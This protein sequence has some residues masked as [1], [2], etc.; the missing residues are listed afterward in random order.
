M[1]VLCGEVAGLD[2]GEA[3]EDLADEEA[4]GKDYVGAYV[5]GLAPCWFGISQGSKMW[6]E[7][8]IH[9]KRRSIEI[10]DDWQLNMLLWRKGWIR[11]TIVVP[12]PVSC[13]ED[14]VGLRHAD[15]VGCVVEVARQLV[16]V[17]ETAL[18]VIRQMIKRCG[19]SGGSVK[20]E[21]RV[22]GCK[23]RSCNVQVLQPLGCCYE[24]CKGS[25][26][27]CTRVARVDGIDGGSLLVKWE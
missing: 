21:E 25:G 20:A 3:G 13:P 5:G 4:F 27:R 22:E 15:A 6:W 14:F 23:E 26:A 18:E 8:L 12:L 11:L 24:S 7:D 17:A 1:A 10:R 19:P 2:G 9:E 16:S